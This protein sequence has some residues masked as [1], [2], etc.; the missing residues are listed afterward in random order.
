[1]A[2]PRPRG[3]SLI[4]VLVVIA[5]IIVLAAIIFPVYSSARRRAQQT[6]CASNLGQIHKAL[7]M[8]VM[9]QDSGGRPDLSGLGGPEWETAILNYVGTP[10]V[11]RCPGADESLTDPLSG[12]PI[13]YGFHTTL[14][15]WFGGGGQS[16]VPPG[17]D[18][19]SWGPARTLLMADARVSCISHRRSDL[20]L[21]A[22]ANAPDAGFP[23][24]GAK[25]RG[26]WQRHPGGSNACFLDGHVKGYNEG[27]LFGY[28]P[29]VDG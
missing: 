8:Y 15:L 13:G 24:Q 28:V 22:Y 1:M 3:F 21:V 12:R 27:Q 4:E 17:Y 14:A 7:F 2:G 23:G 6:V 5:I 10:E 18:V 19:H 9:D 11:L 16:G 25:P 26:S 20:L 29:S